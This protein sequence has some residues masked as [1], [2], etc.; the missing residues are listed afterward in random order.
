V[1]KLARNK[2][3]TGVSFRQSSWSVAICR[4]PQKTDERPF[5]SFLEASKAEAWALNFSASSFLPH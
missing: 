2:R 3:Y 5:V 4:D 1:W